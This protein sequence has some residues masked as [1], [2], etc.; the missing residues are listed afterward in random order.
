MN[1]CAHGIRTGGNNR[2]NDCVKRQVA[3]KLIHE[4]RARKARR[5]GIN[6]QFGKYS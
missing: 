2:E 6:R 3:N 1:H 5:R 4:G